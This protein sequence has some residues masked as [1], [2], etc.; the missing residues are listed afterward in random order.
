LAATRRLQREQSNQDVH[1]ALGGI[2]Q[3]RKLFDPG[4][5][6]TC[7]LLSALLYP[8]KGWGELWHCAFLKR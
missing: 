3:P 5:G 1:H 4:C 6:V 7:S 8:V 2:T